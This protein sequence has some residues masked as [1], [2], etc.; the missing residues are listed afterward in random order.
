MDCNLYLGV[1]SQ[2]QTSEVTEAGLVGSHG[3]PL[4]LDKWRAP[5][6][7]TAFPNWTKGYDG[8][9]TRF[10]DHVTDLQGFFFK[11]ILSDY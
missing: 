8:K 1:K 9:E 5:K 7:S 10:P 4:N 2:E 6:C 3:A 11:L